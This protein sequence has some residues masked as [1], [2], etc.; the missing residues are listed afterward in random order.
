MTAPALRTGVLGCASIAWRRVLPAFARTPEVELVAVASRDAHKAE[1]FA[2]RFSCEAVTGYGG[3]LDRP[4]IDALYLPLPTGLHLEWA[5]RALRAGKHV[6]VEKPMATTRAETAEL[7]GLARERGLVLMENLM[8]VHHSQ[9]RT[10]RALVDDGTIGEIREFTAEFGIPPPAPS[11]VRW[12]P[13]LG[14][15]ALLDMAVYPVRAARLFLGF[16][17]SLVGAVL[18][19]DPVRRVEVAGSVLL[20]S[21]EGVP[22]RLAFGCERHYRTAYTLWGSEGRI[23]VERAFTPL[24]THQPVIRVERPGRVEEITLAPDDQFRTLAREFARAALDGTDTSE[25]G[26]HALRQ[27]ELLDAIANEARRTVL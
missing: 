27:A 25:Y 15:G 24:H 5:A 9:H 12:A 4:D 11:D 10:V 14:G 2:R 22:A 20:V 13:E 7:L 23:V 19:I 18:R 17:L 6:L 16:G 8:F 21:D 26:E 1:T 3:L